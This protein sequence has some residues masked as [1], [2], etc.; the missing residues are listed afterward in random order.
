MRKKSIFGHFIMILLCLSIFS[1][2]V[3]PLAGLT[4]TGGNTPGEKTK[5]ILA[6]GDSITSGKGLDDRA[7]KCYGSLVAAQFGVTGG[8]YNNIAKD[9]MTSAALKD[10][11]EEAEL[12]VKNADLMII[13]TGTDDIMSIIM[14]AV[15]TTAGGELTYSKLLSYAADA[16]YVKRLND[17]IDHTAILNAVAKYSV[18][19]GNI[20]SKVKSFNPDIRIVFLSLY[21]PFDGVKELASLKNIASSPVDLM[22]SALHKTAEENGCAVADI[23]TAFAGKA[24]QLTNITS[25]DTSPNAEGHRLAA[26]LIAEYISALPDLTDDTLTDVTVTTAAVTEPDVSETKKESETTVPPSDFIWPRQESHLWIYIV[27]AVAVSGAGI[28]IGMYSVKS[29]TKKK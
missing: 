29:N 3:L 17:A 1:A 23:F 10:M 18:N 9:D 14:T 7:G 24:D 25:L 8:K 11:L 12:Y 22:N 4:L 16:E 27:I 15:R 28:S 26:S 6:A 20:I 21:N 5:A 2:L 19:L 13:S